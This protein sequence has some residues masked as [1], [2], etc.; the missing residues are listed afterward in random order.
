[1]DRRPRILGLIGVT[2]LVSSAAFAAGAA[3]NNGT[4][5]AAD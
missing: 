4:R 3:A 2:A 1:M 5:R